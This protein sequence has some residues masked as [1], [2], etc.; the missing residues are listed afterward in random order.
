MNDRHHQPAQAN[1]GEAA[2]VSLAPLAPSFS[3]PQRPT[4]GRQSA[5][6]SACRQPSIFNHPD[7]SHGRLVDAFTDWIVQRIDALDALDQGLPLV[8]PLTVTFSLGSTAPD[9]VLREYERFYARLCRL[10]MCNHERPSKRHLLPFALAFR[11]DPSTRPGKHRDRPSAFAVFS[12]H[13]SVAPHVH[14]LVVVHPTLADRFLSIVG[15][16]EVTW[17]RIPVRTVD[18]TSALDAPTYANRSLY[19]DVPF[20]VK[21]RELMRADPVGSRP[22]VRDRIRGVV[23]YCAKLGRRRDV[24]DEDDLF[25]V[26]P[27]SGRSRASAMSALD[28]LAD[29][30]RTS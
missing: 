2:H 14:S 13:P 24:I 16:L 8:V 12:N 4:A 30:S 20:A 19:A 11:D 1:S 5:A 6:L 26:L 27:P 18:P 21:I 9:Q 29:V 28:R 25:I 15:T 7:A 17:R 10:L 23:E 22:L 3:S